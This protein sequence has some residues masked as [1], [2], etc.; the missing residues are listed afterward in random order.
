MQGTTAQIV[1]FPTLSGFSHAASHIYVKEE[2][3]LSL[4][5]YHSVSEDKPERWGGGG[6]GGCWLSEKYCGYIIYFCTHF[7][8]H[9]I[10]TNANTYVCVKIIMN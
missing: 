10:S 9:E 2:T 6:R 4:T 8:L 3:E 1:M 7:C 5:E